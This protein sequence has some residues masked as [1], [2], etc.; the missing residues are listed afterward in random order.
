[1]FPQRCNKLNYST[2]LIKFRITFSLIFILRVTISIDVKCNDNY[3]FF[4]HNIISYPLLPSAVLAMFTL[5]GDHF[6]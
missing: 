1:M 4:Y 2:C 6:I 5:K 3:V